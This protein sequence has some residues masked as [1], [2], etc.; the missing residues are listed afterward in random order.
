MKNLLYI[1][2]IIV[3]RIE[4]TTSLPILFKLEFKYNARNTNIIP[5][6]SNGSCYLH[7]VDIDS[8]LNDKL[9]TIIMLL[10]SLFL[11]KGFHD[12]LFVQHCVITLLG[13]ACI[14][15]YSIP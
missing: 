14:S 7:C 1:D 2:V 15:R 4:F 3:V 10:L 12:N 11:K 8:T 5:I 6:Y 13:V 9:S